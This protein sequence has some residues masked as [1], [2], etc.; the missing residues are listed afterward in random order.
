MGKMTWNDAANAK[1]FAA[2]MTVYEIQPQGSKIEEVARL[3]G[4]DCTAEAVKHQL[5]KYKTRNP[6]TASPAGAAAGN[7]STPSYSARK[8]AAKRSANTTTPGSKGGRKT[9]A[10]QGSD[11]DDEELPETPT[12]ATKTERP[13]S[14]GSALKRSLTADPGVDEEDGDEGEASAFKKIKTEGEAEE[15]AFQDAFFGGGY[16]DYAY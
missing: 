4:P 13:T 7:A 5:R 16:E 6:K 14:G 9:V 3:V 1:L 8:P 15:V 10:R 11:T 12:R 2:I